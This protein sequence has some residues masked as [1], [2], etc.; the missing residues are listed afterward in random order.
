MK[1]SRYLYQVGEVFAVIWIIKGFAFGVTGTL[2]SILVML[3]AP[4]ILAS[5][6]SVW[7]VLS[8]L[9]I[10]FLIPLVV[11]LVRWTNEQGRKAGLE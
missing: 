2:L 10:P 9:L 11:N 5:E 1:M 3:C 8:Y 6:V 7:W 4:L